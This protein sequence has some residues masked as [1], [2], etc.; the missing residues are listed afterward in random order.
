MTCHRF[1]CLTD[2]SVEQGRV[3]RLGAKT[4]RVATSAATSRL[5]KSGDKS[6][7][8][9]RV[10]AAQGCGPDFLGSEDDAHNVADSRMLRMAMFFYGQLGLNVADSTLLVPPCLLG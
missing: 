2:L 5:G 10:A 9:K 1:G 6:P 3:Q 4:G 8:S 7:H